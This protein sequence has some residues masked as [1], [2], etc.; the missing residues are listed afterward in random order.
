M[1]K[2]NDTLYP[3]VRTG[4]LQ[5]TSPI[6]PYAPGLQLNAMDLLSKVNRRL[7]REARVPQLKIDLDNDS[8]QTL[9]VWALAHNWM[10]ARAMKMGYAMYME[11]T[12]EERVRLKGKQI[13]RWQD[14]RVVSG[15]NNTTTENISPAQFDVEGASQVF[16]A[17]EFT[18]SLVVDASG[19]SRNF[20]WSPFG[21]PSRYSLLQEYDKAGNAQT[22]PESSTTD[23]PYDDLMADDSAVT[24][25]HL[26]TAGDN[27]PYDADGV[28]A[29]RAWVLV[30]TLGAGT[31]QKLSTGFFDAPCGFVIIREKGNLTGVVDAESLQW[32]VKA[33]DYK[34][35]HAPSMLE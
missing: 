4:R 10:N 3:V 5:R 18:T 8:T 14:F 33:G 25:A 12:D 9:Q 22:S 2:N 28:G 29:D 19:V 16:G 6:P 27:P 32:T 31:S 21:S 20:T 23:M 1:A 26:Q 24:A 30:A 15:V 17:G 35:V 34:G 13:G 11:N 7:Y